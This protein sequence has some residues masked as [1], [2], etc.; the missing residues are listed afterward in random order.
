MAEA[1]VVKFPF[2][3]LSPFEVKHGGIINKDD[4]QSAMP[5]EFYDSENQWTIA[6]AHVVK[7]GLKEEQIATL[8]FKESSVEEQHFQLAYM[9]AWLN[10]RFVLNPLKVAVVA[11]LLSEM[12]GECPVF[13]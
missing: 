8:R 6:S 11:W 3:V 5:S 12:L 10:N 9:Q 13:A 7:H 4:V 1:T 2:M